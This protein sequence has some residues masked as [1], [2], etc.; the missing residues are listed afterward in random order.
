MPLNFN[1][2]AVTSDAF[3]VEEEDGPNK[4]TNLRVNDT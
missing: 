3:T 4:S 1:A 2:N